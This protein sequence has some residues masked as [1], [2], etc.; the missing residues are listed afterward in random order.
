MWSLE[1]D[2]ERFYE[3]AMELFMNA[4]HTSASEPEFA[5]HSPEQFVY[6]DNE[7]DISLSKEQRLSLGLFNNVSRLFTVNDCAFFSINLVSLQS[8]R[9]QIAHDVHTMIHPIVGQNATICL[10]RYENGIM[11]TFMGYGK[12]CILSDW[13][14]MD[15]DYDILHNK[16]DISNMSITTDEDYFADFVYIFARSYYICDQNP[17][18]YTLLPIDFLS[19]YGIGE[20]DRKELD[21]YIKELLKAAEREY[22]DDYVEY[23]ETSLIVINSEDISIDFDLMLLEMS[24]EDDNPFGEELDL[25]DG[26]YD[27]EE[28]ADEHVEHDKYEYDDV[29]PEIFRDPTLMVKW[30][31][32]QD[33]ESV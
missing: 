14:S 17:P 31:I 26:D 4:G 22:G 6:L 33:N 13:Y 7:S 10:F 1:C 23:D 8:Q 20:S 16:L 21:Q 28:N 15:D 2:S 30:L 9:S 29:D 32:K 5:N 27:G 12:L 25:E 11:L 24:T 3:F 19:H 18:A